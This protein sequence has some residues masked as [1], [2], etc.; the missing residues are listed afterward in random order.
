[1]ARSKDTVVTARIDPILSQIMEALARAKPIERS[2]Y[3]KLAS[4]LNDFNFAM[5]T[6][7]GKVIRFFDDATD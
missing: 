5:K 6:P 2:G 1:M 3:L 4:D 7:S